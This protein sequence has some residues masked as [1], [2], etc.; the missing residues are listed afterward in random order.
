MR[1]SFFIGDP[2]SVKDQILR[3]KEELGFNHMVCRV[4]WPGMEQDKVL[5]TIRQLGKITSEIA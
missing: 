3:Y 1:E 4:Q 5:N 2:E